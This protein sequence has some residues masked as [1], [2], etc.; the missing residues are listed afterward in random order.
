M[1]FGREV[2]GLVL[3]LGLGMA[4]ATTDSANAKLEAACQNN[5]ES[6]PRCIELLTAAGEEYESK[7]EVMAAENRRKA[8][9]FEDRLARMR[10]DEEARQLERMKTATVT[11]D[12][13]PEIM[14]QIADVEDEDDDIYDREIEALAMK[15]DSVR[16]VDLSG[17]SAR[18]LEAAPPPDSPMIVDKPKPVKSVA[19]IKAPILAA[20][21]TPESY[22]RGAHCLL[23]SDH[24]DLKS[25]FGKARVGE[26]AVLIVDT[27]SFMERIDAEMKHRRLAPQGEAC[28]TQKVVV[29]LLRALV[30]PV[31]VDGASADLYSRGQ[32]RLEKELEVRAGL[33]KKQ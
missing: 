17:S 6:D 2:R 4:C 8:K 26:I 19:Q 10:R 21:P 20:A 25:V 1:R 7:K 14:E 28:E 12:L 24:Q 15:M 33:P 9:A 3:L 18:A 30:G 23:K 13:D 5:V 29:E 11:E 32:G 16:D 27:E 31:A 22:L